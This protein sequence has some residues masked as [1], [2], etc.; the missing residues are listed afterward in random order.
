[1]DSFEV[2]GRATAGDGGI[3]RSFEGLRPVFWG[4]KAE[5]RPLVTTALQ[6]LTPLQLTAAS[7][8]FAEGT[9]KSTNHLFGLRTAVSSGRSLVKVSSGQERTSQR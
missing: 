1:M 3:P 8:L 4:L 7:E 6:G 2:F 5:A 9:K